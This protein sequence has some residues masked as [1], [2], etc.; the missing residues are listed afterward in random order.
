[1]ARYEYKVVP[2]IGE[3]R[4]GTFDKHNAQT[5][6][7]QLED[8]I[9]DHAEEGW[10]FCSVEKVDIEVQPGCLGRVLGHSA[11]YLNFDQVIFRRED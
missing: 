1:M 10:E 11:E 8:L 3:I 2:F 7:N 9:Q 6:S 5:V 4:G